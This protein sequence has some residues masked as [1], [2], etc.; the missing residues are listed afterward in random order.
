MRRGSEPHFLA[1]LSLAAL[2]LLCSH[3]FS[4]TPRVHTDAGFYH[5]LFEHH[6]H[7]ADGTSWMWPCDSGIFEHP[8]HCFF[9]M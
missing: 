3:I 6:D 7:I 8:E 2:S 1:A 5:A 9:F 4:A